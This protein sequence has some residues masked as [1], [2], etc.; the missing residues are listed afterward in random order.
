M[1]DG[2]GG[3]LSFR[4]APDYE[5]PTDMNEDNMYE[6]TVRASDG[7]MY[8][9]RMVTVADVDQ[10]NVNEAPMIGRRPALTDHR[11]T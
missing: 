2:S 11:A 8:A 7:T 6:V 3:V 10:D 9:D 5:N 4:T 1:L